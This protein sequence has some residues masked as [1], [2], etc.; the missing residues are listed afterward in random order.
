[1]HP[2]ALGVYELKCA[3]SNTRPCRFIC[4]TGKHTFRQRIREARREEIAGLSVAYEF[5]MTSYVR[6]D[7]N[8]FL[9][10][11]LERLKRRDQFG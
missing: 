3:G 7:N 1:V 2:G 9:C 11:G 10:H 5:P 8:A 4:K 6:G